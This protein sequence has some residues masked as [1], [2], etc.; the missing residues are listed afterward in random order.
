MVERRGVLTVLTH[1]VLVLGV[2]IVAFPV[3]IAFVASTQT[4]V[5]IAQSAPIS[6]I[7]GDH[8]T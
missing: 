3:Y 5:Q 7:P 1:L 6:L 2:I 4:S 8:F